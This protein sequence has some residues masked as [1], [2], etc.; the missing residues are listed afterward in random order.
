[1]KMYLATI[2]GSI[3][4]LNLVVSY[5]TGVAGLTYGLVDQGVLMLGAYLGW[6][7]DPWI[8]AR[9]K[10]ARPG[11]GILVGALVGNTISDCLGAVTDPDMRV[12]V[13]GI[14]NGCLIPLLFVPLIEK[15][16][17]RREESGAVEAT[18]KLLSAW[19]DIKGLKADYIRILISEG[20]DVNARGSFGLTP[21]MRAA[22]D[23]KSPEIVTLLI[24]AG[25]DVNA[26]D[27]D[28]QTP[29]LFAAGYSSTPEIVTLLIEEG[30]EVN[31]RDIDGWTPLMNAV[32]W[33]KSPEIVRLL[34]EAGA[35]VNAKDDDGNTPLMIA[36][37]H[38]STPAI[39]TLLIEAGAV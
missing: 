4:V 14:T 25:A 22:L 20:A 37:Q 38:S 39:V 27:D 3:G 15:M 10:A 29:L 30:A 11:L 33:A 35:D 8:E 34:I 1:M 26:K 24:E 16:K 2:L 5:M 36:A 17:A 18:E 28:G 9:F 31:A 7:I 21:L 32:L 23:S 13:F 19:K 12:M 6:E